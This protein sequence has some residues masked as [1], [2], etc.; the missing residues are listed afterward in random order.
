MICHPNAVGVKLCRELGS[1]KLAH[2]A[3]NNGSL[4]EVTWLSTIVA[5]GEL[6]EA[7]LLIG[8]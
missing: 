5:Q 7:I 3:P 4:G 1:L 6:S 8:Y 2:Q